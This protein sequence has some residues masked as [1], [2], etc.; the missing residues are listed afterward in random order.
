MDNKTIEI[1]SQ[2]SI[3]IIILNWNGYNDTIACLK[4]IAECNY[5]N[6]EIILLDNASADNSVNQIKKW[7]NEDQ[8]ISARKFQ[9]KGNS[10]NSEILKED[11][12]I[13]FIENSENFGFAKGNNIGIAEALKEGFG[14]VMLLNNDTVV[15][16]NFL[17]ELI[18]FFEKNKEYSVASPQIRYYS[19]PEI[20]WNCGG[21]ISNYGSR[22]YFY[23]DK[24]YSELPET[25]FLTIS[26]ITGCALIA[27]AEVFQN[28]GALTEA[29]F[30]GEEDF[31][32][33]MRMK[34]LNV[35]VAC[36]LNSLIYHKVSSS[37]S[38]ASNVLIGK[39][40][41]YYLNRFINLKSFMNPLKWHTWRL[42]YTIYIFLLLKKK[43]HF[44][45]K[46]IR[47]F[48]KSLLK[49]SKKLSGVD[50]QIFEKYINCKF[51]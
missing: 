41:I 15:E 6:F 5:N 17:D 49:D 27:K 1:N 19:K 25:D 29:F 23:D 4:S 42:T 12:G 13:T 40:Y 48:I 39:I 11:I 51:E 47:T 34:K 32:F 35:K 16:K 18:S 22:K 43:H 37:I 44:R 33:S 3:A 21:L 14:Y 50:K 46:T 9:L 10:V 2:P 7:I 38:A 36:V 26:F 28:Y 45:T 30:F 31:E 24:N 8:E 20:I